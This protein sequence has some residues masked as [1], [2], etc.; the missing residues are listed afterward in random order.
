MLLV[1][2]NCCALSSS[3]VILPGTLQEHFHV[4]IRKGAIAV[5]TILNL[6][7]PVLIKNPTTE[8]GLLKKR[9]KSYYSFLPRTHFCDEKGKVAQLFLQ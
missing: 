7:D 9:Q 4:Q 8:H 1:V 2:E 5:A 3:T 6:M